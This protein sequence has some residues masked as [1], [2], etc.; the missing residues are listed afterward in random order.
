M[1]YNIKTRE[2][3]KR[4]GLNVSN[5]N[6]QQPRPAESF[7]YKQLDSFL[8]SNIETRGKRNTVINMKKTTSVRENAIADRRHTVYL[9]NNTSASHVSSSG[10]SSPKTAYKNNPVSGMTWPFWLVN[11]RLLI[12]ILN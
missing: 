3:E 2:V 4:V 8:S 5:N 9:M 1:L 11:L 7:I 10:K 6:I 12:V